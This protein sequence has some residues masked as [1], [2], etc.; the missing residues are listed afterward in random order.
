MA[1]VLTGLRSKGFLWAEDGKVI[2]DFGFFW[3]GSGVLLHARVDWEWVELVGV[4][5]SCFFKISCVFQGDF[6]QCKG[7]QAY[8]WLG[9]VH[10]PKSTGI[11]SEKRTIISERRYV[12]IT[13]G[14]TKGCCIC[15][16]EKGIWDYGL[17]KTPARIGAMRLI[18]WVE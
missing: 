12:L 8:D 4:Y 17:D 3:V 14:I 10:L 16:V 1:L 2:A 11:Y 7:A 13:I 9:F 18:L 5:L 6:G 15:C